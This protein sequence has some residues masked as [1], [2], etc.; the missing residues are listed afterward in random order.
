MYAYKS[1]I[2]ALHDISF[3]ATFKQ[4]PIFYGLPLTK[5][6]TF[7][8]H[9]YMQTQTASITFLITYKDTEQEKCVIDQVLKHFLSI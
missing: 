1:Y 6:Y 2:F 5:N 3:Y 7:Y 9:V 4:L 8:N